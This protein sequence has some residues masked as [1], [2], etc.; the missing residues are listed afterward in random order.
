MSLPQEALVD[1]TP[2][3][4]RSGRG[5]M[6]CLL[7]LAI[8]GQALAQLP[9]DAAERARIERERQAVLARHAQAEQACVGRFQVTACLEAARAERRQALDLLRREQVVLDDARRR[10]RAA[11][12]LQA[13][14]RRQAEREAQGATAMAAA[15]APVEAT[16]VTPG[17]AVAAGPGASAPMAAA[18]PASATPPG[19]AARAAASASAAA[20]RQAARAAAYQRR[21]AQAA[22]HAEAV[23]Q[24]NAAQDAQ[25]PP[26]AGL[27]LPGASQPR[28]R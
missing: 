23:R 17:G 16:A 11:E 18:T 12:R 7:L 26:A 10:A 28:V 14:Q 2:R 6:L 9:D 25:R 20:A 19:A 24:R 3:P 21:Q 15:S 1:A 4:L 22:Q 13:Q 27:P 8:A 5:P